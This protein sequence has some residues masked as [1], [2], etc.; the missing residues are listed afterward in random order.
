MNSKKLVGDELTGALL[1]QKA[2]DAPFRQIVFNTGYDSSVILE[3]VFAKESS[4]G[5]N[6]FT[7][8]VE[9]L[10]IAGVLDPTKVVK[11][12]LQFAASTAGMILLSEALIGN[13]P[14]E[15]DKNEK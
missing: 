7:E 10:I 4:F 9:D 3:E 1:V 15:P 6:A 5:F 12:S 13:A 14:E 2:C 8:K 11:S